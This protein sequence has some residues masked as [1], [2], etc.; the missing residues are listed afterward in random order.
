MC[1]FPDVGNAISETL[2]LRSCFLNYRHV[3]DNHVEIVTYILPY[4][5][6]VVRN[7]DIVMTLRRLFVFFQRF[8]L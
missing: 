6:T 5:T 8:L 4:Q 2:V 7:N 3:I 1:I